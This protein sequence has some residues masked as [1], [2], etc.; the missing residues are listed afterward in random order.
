[1]IKKYL[2]I[3]NNVVDNIILADENWLQLNGYSYIEY[4]ETEHLNVNIGDI[5]SN[6]EI[7]PQPIV[8]EEVKVVDPMRLRLALN[9][10]G[11]RS[12]V[13]TAIASGDQTLKDA[14]EY[15]ISFSIESP[16]LKTMAYALNL[17]DEDLKNIF[18][19]ASKIDL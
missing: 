19:L 15:A 4:N 6:G 16:L 3:N 9:Q 17:T 7:I 8:E 18:I 14:W 10:L 13:E 2:I 11:L 12:V 5:F 1:M